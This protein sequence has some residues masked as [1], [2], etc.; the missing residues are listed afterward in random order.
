MRR[1]KTN[2]RQTNRKL[3][4]MMGM[5][6]LAGTLVV[7]NVLF[8]MFTHQHIWSGADMYT[9]MSGSGFYNGSIS[10][11][12]GSIYDSKGE[13]LAQNVAAYTITACLDEEMKGA[14]GE[15]LYVS[16]YPGTAEKL[17][18]VLG[19]AVD[20]DTLVQTMQNA[21]AAGRDQTELG[22]G[23]KRISKEQ[24]EAIEK[25][26]L[27]GIDF[28]ETST[29][30][31][32]NGIFASHLLGFATYDEEEQRIVGKM[33]LEQSLEEYLRGEDG[34][35]QYQFA[36]DGTEL[37]GTRRVEKQAV[38]GNDV[39]L[40][41]DSNVQATLESS[42]AYTMKNEDA[43][44]AW[45]IVMEVETGKILGWGS[46][47]TF[48]KNKHDIESY[49]NIPSDSPYEPGSVMKGITY[50][51]ALDSGNYPYN[52]EFRAGTFSYT[53]DESTGKISR[54]SGSTAYPS[55]SDALGND[56][57]TISY[58]EG[59]VRS[60][61]V[62]ICCLLADHLPAKTFEEYL[63]R[64]GFFTKVDIPFVENAAGVKNF[65]HPSDILSTGFGQS[66]SV[67]ALQMVQAYSAIFNDG[68]M[69]RPYVVEKI[70]DS[71]SNETIKSWSSEEVGQPISAQ[72]AEY[73]RELM[74]RVVSEE[75]GSGNRYAM[76]DVDVIAK[77]GTGQIAGENGYD[78]EVY[79]S[80]VMMAA[81]A[82]DPK[83]LVYYCFVSE[84]IIDFDEEPIKN[85]FKEA[86]IAANV[87]SS[88][89]SAQEES[90]TQDTEEGNE[91]W[92]SYEMPVL[93]NHSLDYV[94]RRL[95]DMDVECVIIGDGDEIVAQ[96][97]QA[98]ETI[99]SNERIIL[100]SDAS[101][102]TMPGMK[103]WTR[104]DVTAFWKLTGIPISISG[105]GKVVSQSIEAGQ[106]VSTDSEISVKLE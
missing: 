101:T 85:V 33:G 78:D 71:Y 10:A 18:S 44:S 9:R 47:P 72:S 80:S 17:A 79:T 76:E 58:D 60:S 63:N 70:V 40:T 36:S 91:Q 99:T 54:T 105:S 83:V 51:A 56:F 50:A 100:L 1:R 49:L 68:V 97:P 88:Q 62:G 8:A 42:L 73:V 3:L 4:Y 38:N 77:T 43:Q 84:N 28:I 27:P 65:S 46:Y 14:K 45:A 35:I 94:S 98:Q 106:A 53:Y 95:E 16:D 22:A 57:G 90:S 96:Y 103:G 15:Q 37:P 23:T 31:Y 2:Q 104:K 66:S 25:L 20:V 13:V 21:K 32:P 48:D 52:E 102:L 39:Y 11:E 93:V 74:G 59:F 69:M 7:G 67:T 41:L 87:T 34:A 30:N 29:R 5:I 24:K 81:P 12:R 89:S 82:D 75:Y 6:V 55:I 26:N 64:F 92:S 61:N 86:L 19:D